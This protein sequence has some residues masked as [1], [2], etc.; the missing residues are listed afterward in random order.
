MADEKID[1][2]KVSPHEIHHFIYHECSIFESIDTFS[3][4]LNLGSPLPTVRCC[5]A[6]RSSCPRQHAVAILVQ[7][8]YLGV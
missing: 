3:L 7:V 6:P 8:E 2:T 1:R 5:S 4:L